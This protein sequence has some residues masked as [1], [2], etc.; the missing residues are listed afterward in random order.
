MGAHRSIIVVIV[1]E[2]IRDGTTEPILDFGIQ[3]DAIRGARQILAVDKHAR[4]AA[5]VLHDKCELASPHGAWQAGQRQTWQIQ[6]RELEVIAA[7][8][9]ALGIVPGLI[10]D[11]AGQRRSSPEVDWLIEYPPDETAGVA[12]EIPPHLI[13]R[14][15]K[16]ARKPGGL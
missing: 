16:S 12:A 14:V 4:H 3:C 1:H 13:A 9:A 10:L 6:C 11:D 7:S 2:D 8:E 15:R 5:I